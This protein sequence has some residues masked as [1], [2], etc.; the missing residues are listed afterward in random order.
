MTTRPHI[1]DN[2]M[3]ELLGAILGLMAACV[4]PASGDDG[5][6]SLT[7]YSLTLRHF[8]DCGAITIMRAMRKDCPVTGPIH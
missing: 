2:A 6:G 4:T 1:V 7:S 8:N 5:L 3:A